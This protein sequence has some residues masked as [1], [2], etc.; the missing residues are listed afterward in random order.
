ME[1]QKEELKPRRK[2]KKNNNNI[3]KTQREKGGAHDKT[4]VPRIARTDKD[5]SFYL[6]P[7]LPRNP[8]H[9]L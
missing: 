7:K 9:T 5:I 4:L 2:E 6:K 1:N 3:K 8:C